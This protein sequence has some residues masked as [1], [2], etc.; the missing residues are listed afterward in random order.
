MHV[1]VLRQADR[2]VP[3][4]SHVRQAARR[5]HC[6]ASIA[7][8]FSS[9]VETGSRQENASN[10]QSVFKRSGDRFAPGKRVKQEV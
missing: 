2:M 1:P 5:F 9:E 10:N 4:R 7:R 3:R 8:A 6:A